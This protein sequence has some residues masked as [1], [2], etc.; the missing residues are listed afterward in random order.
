MSAWISGLLVVGE[1]CLLV[2]LELRR[3]LRPV[4][5]PKLKRIARNLA[6]STL[7]ALSLVIAERPLVQP[8]SELVHRRE[9]GLVKQVPLPGWL[10]VAL[11]VSLMDYTLYLW[12]RLMHR[13]AWLWRFHLPHHVDLGLDASTALR[14]HFSELVLSVPWR[15]GQ[16]ALIGVSPLS[17]SIWQTALMLSI[18][19]H[20]SNVRLPIEIERRLNYFIVTPRMHGIHHSIIHAE[21]DSNWSSGLTIWDRLHGTLKLNVPQSQ[22]TIGV[23]AYRDKTEARLTEIL[24]MPFRK[25]RATWQ[26][27]EGGEP[28]RAP[29][30][31]ST[32][33]LLA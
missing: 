19:F 21:E 8:L 31:V 16:I 22:I 3:P 25:Q 33:K 2:V 7:G 24:V 23:P 29:I 15:A 9:L 30:P 4:G 14:F 12:H 17:L 5:E 13:W 27:P 1:F 26:L 28:S 6:I 18:L 10:E 11:A 32:E 20:H